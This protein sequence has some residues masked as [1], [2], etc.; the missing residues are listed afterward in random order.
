MGKG[1]HWSTFSKLIYTVKVS[2]IPCSINNVL[3][4]HQTVFE[5]KHLDQSK[6]CFT[7]MPTFQV[8]FPPVEEVVQTSLFQV[9]VDLKHQLISAWKKKKFKDNLKP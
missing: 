6:L 2:V 8:V 7:I 5:C 9:P 4:E 1:R 3:E